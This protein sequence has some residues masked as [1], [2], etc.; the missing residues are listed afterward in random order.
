MSASVHGGV[1][2]G[3]AVGGKDR[4]EKEEKSCEKHRGGKTNKGKFGKTQGLTF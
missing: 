1:A 4:W 2:I 3:I